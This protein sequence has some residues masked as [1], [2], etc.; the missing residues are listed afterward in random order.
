[1]NQFSLPDKTLR[2]LAAQ[3]NLNGTFNHICRIQNTNQSLTFQLQIERNCRDTLIIVVM[4]DE[5]HSLTVYDIDQETHLVLADF[6][7]C[8]I[9]GRMDT[10]EPALPRTNAKSVEGNLL[11]DN[12]QYQQ[13]CQLVSTGG[14][15]LLD[16][17][18]DKPVSLAVHRTRSCRGITAIMAISES[19][20]L[21]LC[22]TAYGNDQQ[23]IDRLLQSL[24]HLV[25]SVA[26]ASHAA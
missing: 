14:T 24:K 19:C 25:M 9:N 13:L 22:F 7:E 10:A 3:I 26:T 21:T 18:L 17:G 11:L 4:G 8:A 20:P 23:S 12:Q 5:K 15:L 6:I 16:L 2:L 1:M